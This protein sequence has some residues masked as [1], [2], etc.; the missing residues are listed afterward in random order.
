MLVF[1]LTGFNAAILFLIGSALSLN[2]S[3][4]L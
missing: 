2:Y 3:Q 1:K 4:W